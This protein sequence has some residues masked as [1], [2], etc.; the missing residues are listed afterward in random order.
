MYRPFKQHTAQDRCATPGAGRCRPGEVQ[1]ESTPSTTCSG[2][3][4]S[5]TGTRSSVTSGVNTRHSDPGAIMANLTNGLAAVT[6]AL[7]LSVTGGAVA[8][9]A[10]ADPRETEKT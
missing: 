3:V 5:V 9:P 4:L 10:F 8:G 2:Q 6:A 7:A 1:R